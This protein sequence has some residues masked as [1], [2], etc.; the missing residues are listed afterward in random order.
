MFYRVRIGD[1]VFRSGDRR[2]TFLS[3]ELSED[4]RG[5]NCRLEISDP[6]LVLA[7]KYFLTSFKEGGIKVPS[8]LLAAPQPV[9]VASPAAAA[10]GAG[11]VPGGAGGDAEANI[12]LIL[13]ECQKQGV[14][15]SSHIAYILATAQHESNYLPVEE[16]YYL[17]DGA[18]AF[19]E[20]LHYYP[21]F[22]RGFVQLT[23]DYNYRKYGELMG[24]DFMA[25][26]NLLL[27]PDVAAFILVHG[28]KTGGFTGI[29]LSEFGSGASF[30]FV[31]ARTIVNGNDRDT[32][33]AG[34]A[35]EWLTKLPSYM[36][37]APAA[38]VAPPPAPTPPPIQDEAKPDAMS[39]TPEPAEVVSPQK[40]TEIIIEAGKSPD[41]MVAYHF[42]H[43]GTSAKGRSP[44]TVAFT[45][46]SI[47]WQMSRRTINSTWE[48]VTLRDVAQQV[49]DA[50]GRSLSME[51]DGPTYAFL[52]ATGITWMD[53][54]RREC[55]AI[56]Y[57]I[58]EDGNTLILEPYRPSFTGFVITRNILLGLD[59]ADEAT[60]ETQAQPTAAPANTTKPEDAAGESVL[61]VNPLSGA[62]KQVNP[63][64][65]TGAG[66]TE[67]ALTTGSPA[68]PIAGVVATST[69]STAVSVAT[70]IAEPAIPDNPLPTYRGIQPESVTGLPTQQIGSID[71]ADGQALAETIRDEARRVKGYPSSAQI[72]TTQAAL[73]LAP[74]SIIAIAQN[75]FSSPEAREAFATEWRV[76][77]VK[78][79]F[80]PSLQTTLDIYKPQAQKAPQA[81][82]TSFPTGGTGGAAGMAGTPPAAGSINERVVAAALAYEG[83]DTS[84]GPDGGRNACAWSVNN[85]LSNAGLAR[86]G[87]NEVYV[88]SVYDALKAGRGTELTIDQLQPGD[89]AIANDQ[90]HIGIVMMGSD[91]K[92]CILS[93]SSSR[94]NWSWRSDLQFDGYYPPIE[95]PSGY[96]RVT[97]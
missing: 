58:S 80:Y 68:A 8:D 70:A 31:G 19:Q 40:G 79:Q 17:G 22:G 28:M 84:S 51:G 64:N 21:Y 95:L 90:A 24:M 50:Y 5:S 78:H 59:F 42:I 71:L 9:S 41:N 91:G 34:Y 97:S 3:V 63:E 10:G 60:A 35:E 49:C 62:I 96:F 45:G 48:N 89:I 47:R 26:P 36:G 37:A 1:D 55:Q 14:T 15:D 6:Q 73:S 88:P 16:G 11:F 33:I 87:T 18:K 30:D 81:A 66:D 53:L 13:A 29:G 39:T 7:G 92:L 23:W 76:S 67:T 4:A 69:A 2:L 20:T 94:A 32:L 83:T 85:V 57:R 82:S 93:N 46:K 75:C 38:P 61:E 52:D 65:T 77:N 27:R 86:I 74:G 54:L 44:D 43:T 72:L 12:R 56:G 25:D